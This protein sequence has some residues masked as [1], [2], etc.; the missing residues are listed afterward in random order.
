MSA[1][2]DTNSFTQLVEHAQNQ[3]QWWNRLVQSSGSELNPQKCCCAFYYWR[4]DKY[5]ILRLTN[6]NQHESTVHLDPEHPNL[7]IPLLSIAEGTQYLGV[8]VTRNGATKPMED[9]V[10]KQAVTYTRA[11]Q[12]THMSRHKATVLYR[13]C[14]LPAI[15]YSFPATW[16]PPT[17]LECIHCVSTLMILNKMGFHCN[18]PRSMVFAPHEVGGIGLLNLI[19]EQSVQQVLILLRHL[20]ARMPLGQAFK[21]LI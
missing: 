9:H 8:Y 11:F 3:L 5:G 17:F 4:P 2:N 12:C 19:H 16:M 20:R 6:P 7:T 14:F 13:S 10:W 21:L 15:T 1:G 18:L